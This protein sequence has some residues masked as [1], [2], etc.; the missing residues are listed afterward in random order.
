VKQTPAWEGRGLFSEQLIVPK[1]PG[2]LCITLLCSTGRAM[3]KQ[4]H[5]CAAGFMERHSLQEQGG[6]GR[7]PGPDACNDS[8]TQRH[9]WTDGQA[10]H[11]QVRV[12]EVLRKYCAP[13]E[14]LCTPRTFLRG[15]AALSPS[16]R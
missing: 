11:C 14:G 13:E 6:Q 2:A 5:S 7:A 8:C 4:R 1:G 3:G 9:G 12:P 15:G 10:Q 16:Q